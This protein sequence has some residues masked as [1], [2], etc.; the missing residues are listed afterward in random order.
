MSPINIIA[1]GEVMAGL[2]AEQPDA[3][4]F[5]EHDLATG[6]GLVAIR[7]ADLVKMANCDIEKYL[8]GEN[9]HSKTLGILGMGPVSQTVIRQARSNFGM[10]ILYHHARSMPKVEAEYDA[11]FLP[12]D[13]MLRQADLICVV[14]PLPPTAEQLMRGHNQFAPLYSARAKAIF[15]AWQRSPP[16]ERAIAHLSTH[17]AERIHLDDLAAVA[18]LSKFH[19][20]R[21]FGEALG[22]TPHRY[23]MLLRVS[24]AQAMLRGGD[25]IGEVAFCVGFCDQSHFNRYF[26]FL[27]GVTPGQYQKRLNEKQRN[28]IQYPTKNGF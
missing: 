17:Y 24:H 16:I 22:I 14:L 13:E 11:R 19:L 10:K 23:Q 15:L 3:V 9:A 25:R 18:K 8:R 21:L 6:I 5:V 7:L 2:A 26:R 12:V 4:S 27:V 20:V 28:F 1:F